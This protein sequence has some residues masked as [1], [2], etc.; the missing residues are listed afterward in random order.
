M[1]NRERVY[2]NS[3]IRCPTAIKKRGTTFIDMLQISQSLFYYPHAQ[4]LH[5]ERECG[6]VSAESRM[7]VKEKRVFQ[8]LESTS[9]K[10]HARGRQWVREAIEQTPP[11]PTKSEKIRFH[12]YSVQQRRISC[13]KSS[14]FIVLIMHAIRLFMIGHH[15]T[16]VTCKHNS[17]CLLR[18]QRRVRWRRKD[19][20]IFLLALTATPCRSF[21]YDIL[22]V[23]PRVEYHAWSKRKKVA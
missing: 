18:T 10:K 23:N 15:I 8:A 1:L 21:R 17:L 2:D 22:V 3:G 13:I 11:H 16:R 19:V 6:L 5:C 4:G 12:V 20:L 14:C 7:P 9:V